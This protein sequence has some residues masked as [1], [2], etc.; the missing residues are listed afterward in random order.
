MFQIDI[1]N[2]Q[3]NYLKK[4]VFLLK[5]RNVKG[6][7][8]KGRIFLLRKKKKT[9]L[10]SPLRKNEYL[11]N[12]LLILSSWNEIYGQLLIQSSEY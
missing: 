9:E 10:I 5:I 3:I 7:D 12:H 11:N 8:N 4:K 2:L 6:E 1:L